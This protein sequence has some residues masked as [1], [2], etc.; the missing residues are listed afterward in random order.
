MKKKEYI[1]PEVNVM[2]METSTI[3]AGSERINMATDADYEEE[4]INSF[5]NSDHGID[6][7]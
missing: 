3:L 6:A 5:W 2:V 1:K 4:N 7:D